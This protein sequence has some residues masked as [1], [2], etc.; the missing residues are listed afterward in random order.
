MKG[1]QKFTNSP[2]TYYSC[3]R[4]RPPSPD[5]LQF[6]LCYVSHFR[7]FSSKS[8]TI[9]PK[10]IFTVVGKKKQFFQSI[11]LPLYQLSCKRYPRARAHPP[12]R[13]SR[14][15]NTS[16]LADFPVST[17]YPLSPRSPLAIFLDWKAAMAP[18]CAWTFS[19]R[20]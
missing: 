12:L 19:W 5:P 18:F 1:R 2:I 6:P 9:N 7:R 14:P 11:S 15:R 8:A 10:L 13:S 17:H 3:N 4:T 20:I 16:V